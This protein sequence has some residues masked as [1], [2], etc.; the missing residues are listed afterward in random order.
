LDNGEFTKT[1]I[2]TGFKTS[3]SILPGAASP[4]FVYAV[5]P[6]VT[7]TQQERPYILIAGDGTNSAFILTPN[8]T[9]GFGYNMA[10]LKNIGGTVGAIGLGDYN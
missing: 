9:T 6:K 10:V 4:G 3:F 2:A 7:S 5:H 1:T 8:G